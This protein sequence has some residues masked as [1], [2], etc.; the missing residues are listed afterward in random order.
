M[1][2]RQIGQLVEELVEFFSCQMS[3]QTTKHRVADNILPA[4]YG[5]SERGI[6]VRAKSVRL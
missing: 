5:L 6:R 3:P 1:R 2:W 4:N